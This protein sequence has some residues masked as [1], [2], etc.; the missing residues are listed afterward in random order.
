MGVR[1]VKGVF[2]LLTIRASATVE[3][4]DHLRFERTMFRKG[5]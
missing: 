3:L 5:I 4:Q 2:V 1:T